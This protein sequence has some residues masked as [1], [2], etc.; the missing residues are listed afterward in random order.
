MHQLFT[1]REH[2]H[3]LRMEGFCKLQPLFSELKMQAQNQSIIRDPSRY[4]KRSCCKYVHGVQ[5]F[6]LYHPTPK[7]SQNRNNRS[8]VQLVFSSS[9]NIIFVVIDIPW[10]R[11]RLV[12]WPKCTRHTVA[13]TGSAP[14]QVRRRHLRVRPVLHPEHHPEPDRATSNTIPSPIERWESMWQCMNHIPTRTKKKPQ[15]FVA[16]QQ[17]VCMCVSRPSIVQ[18]LQFADKILG[19]RKNILT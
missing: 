14:R 15:S 5:Q 18:R 12:P 8:I 16:C 10:P 13:R 4:I 1:S 6:A 3:S 9:R 17:H 11:R 7:Q 19:T 2:A